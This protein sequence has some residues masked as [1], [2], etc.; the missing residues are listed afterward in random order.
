MAETAPIV[1][2]IRP[3]DTSPEVA[4]A[5]YTTD[6]VAAH[7]RKTDISRRR[8]AVFESMTH[9]LGQRPARRAEH[10]AGDQQRAEQCEYR[11]HAARGDALRQP[12]KDEETQQAA[13]GG[14]GTDRTLSTKIQPRQP[15]QGVRGV[16]SRSV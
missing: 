15:L 16:V 9:A 7:P 2:A 4:T 12:A 14:A 1:A 6:A 5:T 13:L 11:P 10:V 8:R 3:T